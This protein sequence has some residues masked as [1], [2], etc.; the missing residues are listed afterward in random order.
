[1]NSNFLNSDT[2]QNEE[3]TGRFLVMPR[4]EGKTMTLK[5][6][7][8][9]MGIKITSSSDFKDNVIMDSDFQN[10]EGIY[11]ENIGVTILNSSPAKLSGI[12]AMGSDENS[13]YIIEP[14]RVVHAFDF[15]RDYLAGYRDAVNSLSDKLLAEG[16][17]EAS[18]PE[19][20]SQGEQFDVQA[21]GS[22]WGLRATRV[23]PPIFQIQPFTGAGIKVCVLDTGMDLQHPDFAGRPI[24]SQSFIAGQAVQD[25]H[26]HGTHCVGTACGPLNPPDPNPRYGVAH[27]ASIFVGKVLS[28]AGSGSDGGILAGIN[29]AVANG[30]QIISMSLGGAANSAAFSQVFE[31]VANNALNVKKVLIVAAAGNDSRRSLG[32]INPVSHPANCPSI[33][34]VGAVSEPMQTADFSNRGMYPPQGRVDIVGPGVAVFSSTKM[35]ARYATWNGT[36]M[37]TPHVAGIAA[38]WAQSNAALRG[39]ALW[40]KLITTARPLPILTVDAG[41]GLVQAPARRIFIPT[42]FPFSFPIPPVG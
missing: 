18:T 39:T 8:K 24:V 32:I 9:D 22:T 5:S 40:Q 1:M 7:E 13:D 17:D 3:F 42:P 30:C 6:L 14:E 26:G 11:L 38:L 15:D 27:Q 2:P 16:K 29:W 34:A 25:A 37:A 12:M 20:P 23:V 41:A 21:I 10:H 33:M 31:N 36:S 28:N 19:A 35:P 4:N